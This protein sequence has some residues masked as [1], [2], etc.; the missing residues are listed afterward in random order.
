VS[1]RG[2][3][4]LLEEFGYKPVNKYLPP[5]EPA[6]AAATASTSSETVEEPRDRLERLFA[7]IDRRLSD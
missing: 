1:D 6:T 7:W 2:G 5:R 4:D 3:F